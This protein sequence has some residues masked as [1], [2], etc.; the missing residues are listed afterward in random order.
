[1]CSRE[2]E[3]ETELGI[4]RDIHI[5][6]SEEFLRKIERDIKIDKIKNEEINGKIK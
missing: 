6:K 4:E 1:M 5:I 3:R 2:R